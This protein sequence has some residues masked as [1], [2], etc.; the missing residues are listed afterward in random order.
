VKLRGANNVFE[1]AKEMLENEDFQDGY[2]LNKIKEPMRIR[3][4]DD[5]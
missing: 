3:Y 2:R 1:I 4:F 5:Y